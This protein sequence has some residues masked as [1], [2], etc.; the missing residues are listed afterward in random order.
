MLQP[1][2]KPS[3]I[4]FRFINFFLFFSSAPG[5]DLQTIIDEE[6]IPFESDV[7]SY[8]RQTAEGLDYLHRR[9]IAHLDI[10]VNKNIFFSFLFHV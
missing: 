7:V 10:K 1:R 5:G 8:I 6:L 3:F 4:P 2:S 9:K